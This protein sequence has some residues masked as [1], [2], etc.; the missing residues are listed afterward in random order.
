MLGLSHKGMFDQYSYPWF[1]LDL[2]YSDFVEADVF[3]EPNDPALLET[4]H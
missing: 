4:K 2:F 3:N 1:D